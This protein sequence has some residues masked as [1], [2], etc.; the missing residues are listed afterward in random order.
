MAEVFPEPKWITWLGNRSD[1]WADAATFLSAVLLTIGSIY[2]G[3]IRLSCLASGVIVGLLA[4]TYRSFLM[5]RRDDEQ[6]ELLS[7]ARGLILE[8]VR[9]RVGPAQGVSVN[10]FQVECEDQRIL[11][12]AKWGRIGEMGHPSSRKFTPES[13]TL[14]L[15]ASG[16]GRIINDTKTELDGED[17]RENLVYRSFVTAPVYAGDTLFGVITVDAKQK[18]GFTDLD[19][20]L[21]ANFGA[22]LATIFLVQGDMKTISVKVFEPLG[23]IS[24]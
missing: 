21:L 17:S 22:K 15:A 3:T 24:E 7:G 20:N 4:I 13:V 14:Q 16:R 19:L 10:F 9:N 23:K 11:S 1:Y 18:N 6:Q 12:A 2:M 5:N 8:F